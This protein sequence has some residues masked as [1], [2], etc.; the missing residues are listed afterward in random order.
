MDLSYC[1]RL[2]IGRT[3][4]RP[5]ELYF[6]LAVHSASFGRRASVWMVIRMSELYNQLLKEI[7]Y[8]KSSLYPRELLYKAHGAI[9]MAHQLR[10][11]STAEYLALETDCVKD[12]I[13]NPKYF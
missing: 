10:A 6:Y 3:I 11:I 12:G 5:A 13:N 4:I 2:R 1:G 9:K 7:A 8:A